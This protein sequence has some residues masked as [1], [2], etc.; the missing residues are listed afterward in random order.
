MILLSEFDIDEG[1]MLRSIYPPHSISHAESSL[2]NIADL[3]LPEGFHHR[4]H[5]KYII[6]A[7]K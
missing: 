5:G 4:D 1:S 6:I 2:E 7:N 3:M